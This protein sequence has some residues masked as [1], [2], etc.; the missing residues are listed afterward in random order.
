MV[1]TRQ[2][3]IRRARERA[4]RF[5]RQGFHCSEAVLRGA[6]AAL[7]LRLDEALLRASTGPRGGGGGYGDRCGVLEAGALLIGWI[8]GRPHHEVSLICP[9][10]D[11]RRGRA[12]RVWARPEEVLVARRRIRALA[13]RRR[14]VVTAAARCAQARAGIQNEDIPYSLPTAARVHPAAGGRFVVEGRRR[15]RWYLTTV[16]ELRPSTER[17]ERLGV[18]AILWPPAGGGMTVRGG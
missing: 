1:V 17:P 14:G 9:R 8:F 3:L 16:V 11:L 7:G 4:E 18:A 12:E 6:A 2:T 13:R 10:F 15:D 5:R